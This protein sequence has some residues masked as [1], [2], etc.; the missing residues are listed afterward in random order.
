MAFIDGTT[1]DRQL[2]SD[3]L[4]PQRRAAEIACKI[5]A[6][7]GHAH[8]K[9][10]V[11]RDLKPANV[12]IDSGG[13]PVVMDFGL[14][15]RAAHMEAD[16]GKL[17]RP[18][19]IVGTP[20][21]MSPEQVK[22]E[23]QVVGPATDIYSLGVI[24]F[25]MLTGKTPYAGSLVEVMGQILAAP[26]PPVREF[27]PD[28]DAQLEAIC[29]KAMA[30][31]T[32]A[33]FGSMEEFAEALSHYLRPS[34]NRPAPHATVPKPTALN[35]SH[36]PM[37]HAANPQPINAASPFEHFSPPADVPGTPEALVV[38]RP[39]YRRNRLWNHP[40]SLLGMAGLALAGLWAYSPLRTREGIPVPAVNE[41]KSTVNADVVTAKATGETAK[42]P[43]ERIEEFDYF[44]ESQKRRGFRRVLEV[45]IGGG[46]KMEFVRIPK[47][48]FSMG[49]PDGEPMMEDNEKP[50]HYVEISRDFY[51]G[52]YEVTQAQYRA[53]MGE[54]PS[55][56]QSDRL[57][58][59][60]VNW[61]EAGKF[62]EAL[63]KKIKRKASLPTEAQWEYACRAGTTTPFSFGSKLNGVSANCDGTKPYGLNVSGTDLGKTTLVGSYPPN[64][65]GLYD[66]HG[67]VWEFCRDY[68][69]PYDKSQVRDPFQPT[70]QRDA[71]RVL[72]GGSWTSFAKSCRSAN[73]IWHHPDLRFDFAGFRVC[74]AIDEGPVE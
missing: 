8:R 48:T 30:K 31:D 35:P 37:P 43:A 71:Y 45:D 52:K 49:A 12:M 55:R 40:I 14:A 63:S 32:S 23:G 16:E 56:F 6:A 7:L 13:E 44:I 28:V 62:C 64:P 15:K 17:T 47:G 67:N 21:Y 11:H 60:N 25:E 18:G 41:P 46:Q 29:Q 34:P 36:S 74:L 58:V 22:G 66:M 4:M 42:D 19:A 38:T 2:D 27:R 72:R 26:L 61:N 65:W 59:E 69:A 3:V 53:T 5:A 39:K 1:L 68:F 51:L 57:P 50:Q 33:R 24:L 54:N 73:R 70:P 10:T 20:S 9:G